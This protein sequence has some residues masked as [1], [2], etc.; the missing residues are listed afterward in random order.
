MQKP[1]ENSHTDIISQVR[2]LFFCPNLLLPYFV[3]V[4]SE[5]S[6]R[7]LICAGLSKSSL[8][9]NAVSADVLCAGQ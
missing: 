6:A 7:L 3:Y 2:G 8:L 4:R 5:G 1:P 9:A